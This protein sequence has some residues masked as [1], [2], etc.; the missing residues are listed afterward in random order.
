MI[1][2]PRFVKFDGKMKFCEY[3]MLPH[4]VCHHHILCKVKLPDIVY[5][6]LSHVFLGLS[7]F[8]VLPPSSKS[9]FFIQLT[10]SINSINTLCLYQQNVPYSQHPIP[11]T[12]VTGLTVSKTLGVHSACKKYKSRQ[13]QIKHQC[14]ACTYNY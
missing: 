14:P 12:S 9:Q 2:I 7:V 10:S 3:H 1:S 4:F 13:A 5:T 8:W 11:F 6:T